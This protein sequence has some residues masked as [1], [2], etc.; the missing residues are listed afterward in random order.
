MPA[1]LDIRIVPDG[2]AWAQDAAELLRNV[3]R[4]AIKAR[5]RCLLALSGG[6]TPKM[7]YETLT[8]HEWRTEFDWPNILF[9]FGDE[10]CLPPDHPDSNFGM[11]SSA[12]FAPLRIPGHQISR[13]RGEHPDP[14]T[15]AR[16]YEDRIRTMTGC[17]APV[18]P[19]LDV[20]LLG[21]GNDGH[22][23]SLFP[24]TPALLNRTKLV[25]VGQSPSGVTSRL[26]I[27]LAVINQANVV[28]FLVTGSGKAQIV[29][30]ILESSTDADRRLPASMVRPE[31]G[32]LI[33]LLD[34]SAAT[35][36]SNRRSG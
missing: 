20:V 29:R 24:N 5:G 14:A 3:T 13:M 26:T 36:L 35:E 27:T 16:D 4:Q 32:R 7:L 15:A 23:A 17:P 10:R 31:R 19:R 11:A 18:V 21:L 9:L 6:S 2:Q 33:W 1:T 30:S 8:R 12:L 25:T 34:S 22:T 28:V